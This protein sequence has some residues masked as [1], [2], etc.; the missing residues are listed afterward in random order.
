VNDADFQREYTAATEGAGLMALADW[1]TIRITGRDRASFLHNMCTNDVK[2]LPAGGGC[3]AFFT[4]VKGKVIAHAFILVAEESNQLITVPG[5]GGRL[6]AHL[7]RYIIREDVQLADASAEVSW[8]LITGRH[9]GFALGQFDPSGVARLSAPWAHANVRM[10]VVEVQVARCDL[11]WCGG[12]LVGVHPA[13][14]QDVCMNVEQAGVSSCFSSIWHAI[15]VESAWPLWGVD[16]DDSNLPQ[17]VNR[18]AQAVHFRK[19]CYLG[20]ETVARID[21]LGHVNKKLVQI[22]FGG[23]IVPAVGADMTAAGQS[24]GR[25]SSSAWSPRWKA[26]ALAMIRR[27]ANEPGEAIECDGLSGEVTASSD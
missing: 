12:Y 21:A 23:D 26:S 18:D 3:E 4:D 11:P 27:G 15:R 6:M 9:A 19:G 17:E 25:V 2:G 24:V 16:F 1:T 10:G 13:H 14:V 20:Q 22:R 7:D 8:Q 5:Q